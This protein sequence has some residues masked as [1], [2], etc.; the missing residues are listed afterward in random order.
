MIRRRFLLIGGEKGVNIDGLKG[1]EKKGNF[2][3][4]CTI[5]SFLAV[6]V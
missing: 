1:K 5:L 6:E 2:R 3:D 4:W